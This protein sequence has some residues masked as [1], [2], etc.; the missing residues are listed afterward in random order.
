[1]RRHIGRHKM[2]LLHLRSPGY[3][4]RPF[5]QT[6]VI[7]SA[8]LDEHGCRCAFRACRELDS[9]SLAKMSGRSPRPI[10]LVEGSGSPLRKLKPLSVNRHEEIAGTT[11]NH[12]AGQAVT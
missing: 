2:K 3:Q 10:L 1:M 8:D 6:R 9:A 12:L 7:Q 4:L 11:R 5:E